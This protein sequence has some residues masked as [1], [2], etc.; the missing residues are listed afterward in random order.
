MPCA[1]GGMK[2]TPTA[3]CEVHSNVEPMRLR[4]EA[5]VVETLERYQRQS[6]NHPNK[7]ILAEVR[8]KQRIK[9]KLG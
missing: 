3:V 7:C 9:K 8:P 1:S 4:R 5:A 6:E 2:S